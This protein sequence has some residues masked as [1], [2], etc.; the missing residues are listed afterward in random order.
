MQHLDPPPRKRV[1][2][3]RFDI[4]NA[5]QVVVFPCNRDGHQGPRATKDRLQFGYLRA[6]QGGYIT[7]PKGELS[8]ELPITARLRAASEVFSVCR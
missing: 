5:D 7:S 3:F 1:L 6:Q 4:Q 2:S 8:D